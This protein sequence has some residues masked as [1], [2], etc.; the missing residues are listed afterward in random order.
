MIMISRKILYFHVS[1][2]TL[3]MILTIYNSTLKFRLVFDSFQTKMAGYDVD[4]IFY[5]KNAESGNQ[6]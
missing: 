4:A 3:L 2:V 1:I 5:P 6:A